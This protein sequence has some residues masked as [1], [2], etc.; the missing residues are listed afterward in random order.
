MRSL[1]YCKELGERSEREQPRE[2][3]T[4]EK[5]V[6]HAALLLSLQFAALLFN[7]TVQ[8]VQ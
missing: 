2:R 6:N 7:E 8:F 5:Q 3:E 4:E 1:H